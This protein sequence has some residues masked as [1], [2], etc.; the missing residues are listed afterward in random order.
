MSILSPFIKVAQA[1][2]IP[3][4]N[5]G[6]PVTQTYFRDNSSNNIA[7]VLN[8][9]WNQGFNIV[10][11]VMGILAVGALTWAGIQYI[12][13]GGSADKVKRARQM[14]VNVV[15]GIFILGSAY[16]IIAVIISLANALAGG[17]S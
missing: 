2:A 11:L 6:S 13:A 16:A 14:I 1:A 17:A 7:S 12:T 8:H 4:P 3:N 5:A 10:F 15:L 9:L